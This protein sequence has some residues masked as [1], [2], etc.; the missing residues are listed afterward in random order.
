MPAHTSIIKHAENKA[1]HLQL[2]NNCLPTVKLQKCGYGTGTLDWML[3][4]VW[5]QSRMKLLPFAKDICY[6]LYLT[7]K[8]RSLCMCACG[9]FVFLSKSSYSLFHTAGDERKWGVECK[10]AVSCFLLP[11]AC[12]VFQELQL[13]VA[14]TD[15]LHYWTLIVPT[16]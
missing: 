8:W 6:S 15:R 5:Q 14:C 7:N 2:L 16:L 1:K 4:N 13:I 3:L 12:E 9:S 11:S 10:V